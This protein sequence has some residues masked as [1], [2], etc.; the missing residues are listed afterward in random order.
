MIDGQIILG[1]DVDLDIETKTLTEAHDR[2][3]AYKLKVA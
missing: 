2:L 3:R 1:L